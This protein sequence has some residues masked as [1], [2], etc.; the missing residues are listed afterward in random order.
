VVGR[1]GAVLAEQ[2][3]SFRDL[4]H[5]QVRRPGDELPVQAGGPDRVDQVDLQPVDVQPRDARTISA[6][7]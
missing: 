5:R 6:A 1:E 4:L 2:P 7:P 3:P